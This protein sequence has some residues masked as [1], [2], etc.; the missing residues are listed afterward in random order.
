M[1]TTLAGFILFSLKKR[2]ASQDTTYE[3]LSHMRHCL[4]DHRLAGAEMDMLWVRYS[5]QMSLVESHPFSEPR[6]SQLAMQG[7]EEH[8][9][10]MF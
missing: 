1:F 3:T 5:L 4:L 7:G 2:R 6:N 10:V 9:P 8:D